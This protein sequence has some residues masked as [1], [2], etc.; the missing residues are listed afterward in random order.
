MAVTEEAVGNGI[1]RKKLSGK[2]LVLFIILPLLLLGGGGVAGDAVPFVG[3]EEFQVGWDGGHWMSCQ[4]T[5][6][7]GRPCH[8]GAGRL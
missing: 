6:G 7:R 1:A 5:H 3:G 2:K 4:C 8:V